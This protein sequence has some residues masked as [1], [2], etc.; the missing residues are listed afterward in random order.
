[1][2]LKLEATNREMRKAQEELQTSNEELRA[3]N[4][5]L[6]RRNEELQRG[7]VERKRIERH[8][9][10]SEE[11]DRLIAEMI[12][13]FTA[14]FCV[15]RDGTITVES[16]TEGFTALTGYTRDEIVGPQ[17]WLALV[18]P[19]DHA[20][21]RERFRRVLSNEPQTNEFRILTKHCEI[22][23]IRHLAHPVWDLKESRVVRIYSAAE[24]IT[25]RRH[26]EEVKT[27]LAAVVESSEDAILSETLDGTILSWN[28]AAERM[29]GYRAKEALG[30]SVAMLIPSGRAHELPA[31]LERIRE[32]K[33]IR[34]LETVRV[35]KDGRE[36]D[37]SLSIAPLRTSS[38]QVLGA[39][40]IARDISERKR[41]ERALRLSEERFRQ[42]AGNIDSVFWMTERSPFR[43]L[44]VSPAYRE[45]WGRS[46][47]SLYE[48]PMSFL[49]AIHP[50]D[51]DKAFEALERQKQGEATV[52]EYRV[53]RPDGSMRWVL[54]REF[55]IPGPEGEIR[56][57]AGIA[58]DITDRRHAEEALREADR[59]KDE[60]LGVLAHELRNPLWGISGASQVLDRIGE[61][62]PQ[63]AKMRAMIS[64]QSAV[65]ARMVDDLLNVSRFSRGSIALK[66]ESVDLAAVCKAVVASTRSLIKE[67]GQE[68][69][70]EVPAPIQLEADP[71]RLE[72]IL[73]NLL[74]NA[75]KY[76]PPG[77]RIWLKAA[78]EPP[79]GKLGR[80]VLSVRDT[81]IGIPSEMLP[82]VFDVFTQ[83][84]TA[85][86]R[87]QGGLGI[88]LYLVQKLAES[89]G[90]EVS[91]HSEG[92]GRG[93]EF[94]VRLPIGS[95][96]AAE[97]LPPDEVRSRPRPDVRAIAAAA[98]G[99]GAP[100][101]AVRVLVV[102]DV[103]DLAESTVMLLSVLGYEAHMA[104]D[105]RSAI[106]AARRIRP[107]VM[108]LDIGMP[109]MN[110]YEVAEQVRREQGL[111][112]M[113]MVAMTGYATDEHHQRA[114]A[115]GFDHHLV[116]PVTAE[117]LQAV[118]RSAR[119]PRGPA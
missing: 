89:H 62:D 119:I 39:S 115:A 104:H 27:L 9:R 2:N 105:G 98:A 30:K 25:S 116:K 6:Q 94:T 4:D 48:E 85:I 32:G 40:A 108:I 43:M 53:L 63:A 91:A 114:R 37:V 17:G 68:L 45:I 20:E 41:V 97:S 57:V 109:S 83:V 77:G 99:T 81:G 71:M 60:F 12:S 92:T 78:L 74:T 3:L 112:G 79:E 31:I 52:L 35:R 5:E 1:M 11:R 80:V 16:L 90:G 10:V 26:E 96:R 58:L 36:I 61:G 59:R 54:N 18:H 47:R 76:T 72:Q 84:D 93:S 75:A 55:P 70:V 8:L 87:S 86:G 111:Q 42:L 50:E 7:I 13:H 28:A 101:P 33:Q 65:L 88:G 95:P 56:R 15:N 34:R 24:D 21:V 67:R 29:Y 46:L 19:D 82:R 64:H 51:R 117:T 103:V 102:D 106:E 69:I 38:G 22:R 14:S 100:A 23:W 113:L 73:V 44:Y 49:E 66:K 110:G 107:D 118:L